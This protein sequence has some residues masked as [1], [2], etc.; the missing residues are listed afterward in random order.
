MAFMLIVFN[1]NQLIF[2]VTKALIDAL[3]NRCFFFFSFLYYFLFFLCAVVL[4][5]EVVCEILALFFNAY[6]SSLKIAF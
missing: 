1:R 4:V 5:A 6:Q 3:S 2:I